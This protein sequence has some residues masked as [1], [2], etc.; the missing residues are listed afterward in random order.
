M[1]H[2]GILGAIV[3][4]ASQKESGHGTG[5]LRVLLKVVTIPTNTFMHLNFARQFT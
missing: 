3:P 1:G 2:L 5:S 4:A